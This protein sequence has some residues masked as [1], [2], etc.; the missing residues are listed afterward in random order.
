M[1]F[2]NAYILNHIPFFKVCFHSKLLQK[3]YF[4]MNWFSYNYTLTITCNFQKVN[5]N[6]DVTFRA[7]L[8]QYTSQPFPINGSHKIIAPF[9]TDIDTTKG[10]QLWYRSTTQNSV[11]QQGTSKIRSLFP[12]ILNFVASW[13][14]VVTW[15]N[16]AAYN[17]GPTKNITC[18]QVHAWIWT[19]F[20]N[21]F[22]KYLKKNWK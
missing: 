12:N 21:L 9:W 11:L 1:F 4:W 22:F 15:E 3:T 6:G 14:M 10:G 19:V 20:L 17:C 8:T 18:S 2:L 13:M 5:N 7:P 16:V